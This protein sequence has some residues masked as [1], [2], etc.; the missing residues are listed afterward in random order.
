MHKD[1]APNTPPPFRPII[2]SI[3]TYN[4]HLAKFLC[5]LLKPYIP[6]DYCAMDTFTFVQELNELHSYGKFLISFD[7]ESLF[8]NIPLDESISIAIDYITKND[9]NSTFNKEERRKLF[10]LATAQSHFLFN[11]EFFDQIDGVAMG[12][13][14]A[15]VL[16]NL[17]MGHHEKLWLQQYTGPNVLFYRRYV[18][19]T[20]CLFETKDDALLFFDYLNTRHSNIKFTMETEI[21]KKLPFLDILIDNNDPTGPITSVYHKKTYTGMLT[22][23]FSF[24]PWSYKTGLVR[25]LVDRTFRI[26][27]RNNGLHQ[28]LKNLIHTLRRNCFPLALLNKIIDSYRN[29][30][31]SVIAS[32]AVQTVPNNIVHYYKLPY[33]GSFSKVAQNKI[34]LL[35]KRFCNNLDIKL[36]FTSFKISK[37]FNVKD[38]CPDGLRSRVV[39]KFSCAGCN[40]CYIGETRRHFSTRV[41]EHLSSDRNSHIYKHLHS[42]QS[43]LNVCSG[44][45][46]SILDSA[47]TPFQLKIKEAIHIE[48]EKPSLNKQLQHLNVT[49][50]I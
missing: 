6:L 2:S 7:V 16:A 24:C 26:N 36:V 45:C 27:N 39:Y 40:A 19:D 4:Y 32:E 12:S 29:K 38:S 15:P 30:V 47:S 34:R 44:D 20:F 50:N 31:S 48:W 14:L 9:K 23:F 21:D 33:I 11:G 18:D 25:T 43:C 46:F 37:L 28:D 13:P 8:T 3:G 42:S 22:N 41:R 5:K 10:T 35:A 1:H 49:L 17:F